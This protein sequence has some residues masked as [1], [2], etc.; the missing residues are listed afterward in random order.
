MDAIGFVFSPS[1]RR[2]TPEQAVAL[3]VP[4]RGHVRCIAVMRQPSQT[5]LDE[6]LERFEPDEVQADATALSLLR[7]PRGLAVLP[8]VRAGENVPASLPERLL[9]EGPD[10]GAGRATDWAEASR[11][12]RRIALVLAGG[13]S[14]DNVAAAIEQVR[15]FGV[16]VSSGVEES[17]GVKSVARIARFADNARAAFA[18]VTS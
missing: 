10:S 5:L 2:V 15:P 6:V 9:F 11:L 3:A 4:A 1:V 16:D 13:L 14:P 7:I 18:R 17:A 8:V 12:A